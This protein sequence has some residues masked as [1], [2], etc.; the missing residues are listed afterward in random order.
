[1][2]NQSSDQSGGGGGGGSAKPHAAAPGPKPAVS[3]EVQTVQML[4]NKIG[5]LE[6]RQAYLEKKIAAEVEAG[7]TKLKAGNKVGAT[8]HI[9]RKKLYEK[10]LVNTTNMMDQIEMQA[11]ALERGANTADVVNVMRA[12]AEVQKAQQKVLDVE[13]VAELQNEIAELQQEQDE[14]SNLFAVPGD[15]L[16]EDEIANELAE[17]ELEEGLAEEPKVKAKQKAA[18]AAAAAAAA[19]TETL[20]LPPVPSHKV[21]VKQKAPAKE[22][23]ND[24]DELRRLEAELGA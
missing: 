5:E 15:P 14:V 18:P 12:G 23:E 7:K 4:R 3:R 1:M 16:L 22:E 13:K 8:Q 10:D 6:K 19:K 20:D 21:T 2:G 24:E 11:M 17:L 9:K